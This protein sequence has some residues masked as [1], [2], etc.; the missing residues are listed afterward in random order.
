[1]TAFAALA[2]SVAAFAGART[3]LDQ[4]R[5]ELRP[6]HTSSELPI[7]PASPHRLNAIRRAVDDGG[8]TWWRDPVAVARKYVIEELE[9]EASDIEMLEP[10]P[11]PGGGVTIAL[12]NPRVLSAIGIQSPVWQKLTLDR[13][14]EG[15]YVIRTARTD[16]VTLESP[17]ADD[18]FRPKA[19]IMFS[20]HLNPPVLPLSIRSELDYAIGGV[21]TSPGKG[22]A[23]H[24]GQ[25]EFEAGLRDLFPP[26]L[27]GLP[28][29]SADDPEG[30]VVQLVVHHAEGSVGLVS[31]RLTS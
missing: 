12:S 21:G 6:A 29:I 18:T 2:V 22:N 3:F 17:Q 8:R 26:G 14:S 20:G 5:G 13:L 19:P 9:W 15:M 16:A 10:E 23:P 4:E 28:E 1:V 27:P 31:F 25:F 30:V 7:Y 24:D 11:V